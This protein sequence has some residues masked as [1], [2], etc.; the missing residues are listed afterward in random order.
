ISQQPQVVTSYDL[1][2]SGIGNS[3]NRTDYKPQNPKSSELGTKWQIYDNR[4]LLSTAIFRTEIENEVAAHEDG[5][6][7]QYGKKP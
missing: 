5:T 4:L 6:C 3:E 1:A 7:S 2:A